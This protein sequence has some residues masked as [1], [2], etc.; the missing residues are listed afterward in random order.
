MFNARQSVIDAFAESLR[1]SYCHHFGDHNAVGGDTLAFAARVAL[2]T[3]A[4]S[5][6]PYHDWEHTLLVTQVGLEILHGKQHGEGG[7]DATLWRSFLV[8]LLCHDVGYVRGVCRGDRPGRYVINEVGDT[9][10]LARHHTDAALAPYHIERGKCFVEQRFSDRND[11][12]MPFILAAIERT[13]F[14]IPTTPA[15]APTGD[16]PG[17]ARAA[18]LIGQLADPHYISK[19]SALFYEFL[20]TGEA[21][22]LNYNGPA[23]LREGY[24]AFYW[25]TVHAYVQDALQL[26]QFTPNG[27]QWAANL[28]SNVFSEE[29][30]LSTF[31]GPERGF[32]QRI[33]D[34]AIPCLPKNP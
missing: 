15:H 8:A 16:W 27:R 33:N 34:E 29:H 22:R 24:P 32:D 20:E 25:R 5:D 9:V 18:D 6:A 10:A 12:D 11:L 28:H 31:N 23:D 26:L 7:V 17:L 21:A 13:R 4:C 30:R 3:I 2:E 19:V 1:R 14:P